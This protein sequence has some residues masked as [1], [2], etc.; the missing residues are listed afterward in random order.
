MHRHPLARI[1]FVGFAVLTGLAACGDDTAGPP[2]LDVGVPEAG[3][4]PPSLD[5]SV[6]EGGAGLAS[7]VVVVNSDYFSSSSV[8]FLDRD[9][10]LLLD[11]CL[12]TGDGL[13]SDVVLP[14]QVPPGGPVAIIDRT[15]AVVTWLDVTNCAPLGQMSVG[16]GFLANPHDVVMLSA[17]KAY[18][19]RAEENGKPTPAA[20][21]FDEGNDILVV[22][23]SRAM[24]VG[25]IDLAPFAPAGVLPRADRAILAGGLVYVSFN[26][27]S[28]DYASYGEGRIVMI[29]PATDLVTGTI[30]LPGAK[31]CGAMSY[32]A[33][34]NRLFVACSGAYG[35]PAG[36]AAGSAIVSIDLG[37]SPPAVALQVSAATLGSA[38]FSNLA[39]AAIDATTAFAVGVGDFT[40]VP[41]DSLWSLPLTGAAPVKVFESSEGFALGAVLFDV[42]RQRAYVA[43]GTTNSSAHLR[44][45][46]LAAGAF[47]AGKSVTTNP[48]QKLPPRVLAFY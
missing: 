26:N 6:S 35:D 24:V 9:G 28:A 1:W 22:D 44:I 30:D 42:E 31:N 34:A 33:S 46:D 39:V 3:P 43:D 27:I 21:D 10:N 45:F 18:V 19:T 8:S 4:L 12:T 29:D 36:Q 11:G 25:R 20:G 15:N 47:I 17:S 13:S 14:T 37:T 5:G 41:P 16:T 7:G 23:P 32:L 48:T 40:S 38:P 2:G